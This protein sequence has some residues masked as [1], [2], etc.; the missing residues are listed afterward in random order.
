MPEPGHLAFGV[1]PGGAL[2]CRYRGIERDIAPQVRQEFGKTHRLHCREAG[3]EA[4]CGERLRLRQ[5]AGLDHLNES[6]IARCVKPLSRRRQQD[7]PELIGGFRFCLLLPSPD[8]H[9]GRSHH[10]KGA[11]EPLFVSGGQPLCSCR[12]EPCQLLAKPDAA[13]RL[14]KLDRLLPDLGG[15]VRNR[16]QSPFDRPQVE[17]GAADQNGQAA[18]FCR[19]GDLIER[20]GSP[21]RGRPALAGVEEPVEPVRYARLRRVVGP[22]RQDPKIAIDLQAIGVDDRA[23]A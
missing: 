2:R 17:P 11:D 5:C 7:C 13:Q 12:I 1:S 14:M 18:C 4:A 23:A 19:L 8:G 9:S 10:L 20:E 3:I 22:R 16:R 15:D 21:S 6:S